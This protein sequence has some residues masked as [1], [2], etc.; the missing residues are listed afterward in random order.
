[1][2]SHLRSLEVEIRETQH[3]MEDFGSLG[4]LGKRFVEGHFGSRKFLSSRDSRKKVILHFI[5]IIT[6]NYDNNVNDNT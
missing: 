4:A 2:S 3:N 5:A 6:E 1:M